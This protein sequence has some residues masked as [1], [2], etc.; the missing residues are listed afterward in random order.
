MTRAPILTVTLTG[1]GVSDEWLLRPIAWLISRTAVDLDVRTHFCT[2]GDG[3]DVASRIAF[4]R[5]KYPS[6]ICFV[7]RDGDRAG[8]EAR[9]IEIEGARV[10]GM[11][12]QILVPCVPVV[13]SE[14]WLLLDERALRRA[15]GNPSGA[16]P[17]GLPAARDVETVKDPKALLRRA[18]EAA[19]ELGRNRRRRLVR[20]SSD[21]HSLIA[22]NIDSFQGHRRLDA[23][24]RFAADTE[25]AV[26]VWLGA[27]TR[28]A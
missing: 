14:A 28:P 5:A 10:E 22:D 24:D 6:D 25:E 9:R 27:V 4:A 12:G 26:R 7:H 15:A 8:L 13:T 20:D 3:A 19:S 11:E 21:W 1:E 2:R 17:L 23:F 18:M 16:A